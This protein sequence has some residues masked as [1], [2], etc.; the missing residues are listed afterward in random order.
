VPVF[1]LHGFV[2]AAFEHGSVVSAAA[3][4]PISCLVKEDRVSLERRSRG[5]VFFRMAT[6]SSSTPAGA[7]VV[8]LIPSRTTAFTARRRVAAL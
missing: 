7:P 1:V 5:S 8:G 4:A 3:T 6:S 2:H